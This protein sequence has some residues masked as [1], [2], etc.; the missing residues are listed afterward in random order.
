M[1]PFFVLCSLIADLWA[2]VCP[3]HYNLSA[4]LSFSFRDHPGLSPPRLGLWFNSNSLF[5]LGGRVTRL[6]GDPL[7]P[8]TPRGSLAT[9]VSRF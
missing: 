2:G 4:F 6:R 1:N 8:S 5:Q 7:S 3:K 9:G